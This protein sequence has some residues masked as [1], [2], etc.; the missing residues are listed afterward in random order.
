MAA[1]KEEGMR[2]G[3]LLLAA[4]PVPEALEEAAALGVL[5]AVAVG[6]GRTVALKAVRGEP[7]LDDLLREHFLGC[8]LVLVA[9]DLELP[10]LEPAADGWRVTLGDGSTRQLTTAQLVARLRRARPFGMEE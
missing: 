2:V 7:V 3:W 9:G 8:R 5:R 1:A 4:T 10:E 6:Q